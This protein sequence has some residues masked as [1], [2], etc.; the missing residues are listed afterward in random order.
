MGHIL[1]V[2]ENKTKW[3]GPLPFQKMMNTVLEAKT[4]DQSEIT[5]EQDKCE[6]L[7]S[8]SWQWNK[9][10]LSVQAPTNHHDVNISCSKS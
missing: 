4:W 9:G 5:P 7:K 8:A 1:L 10:D 6:W 2:C 3:T